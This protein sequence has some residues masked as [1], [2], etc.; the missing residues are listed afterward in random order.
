[1]K[2]K[3]KTIKDLKTIKNKRVLVRVDFNVPIDD[4]QNVLDTTKIVG[5]METIQYLLKKKAKVIL[6]SHMGRP[7]GK[8][9]E[10]KRLWPAGRELEKLLGK[11]IT[12]LNDCVGDEVRAAVEKMKKGDVILLENLR[13]KKEEEANDPDFSKELASYADIFVQDAFGTAHRAHASTVGVTEHLE[14]VAGLLVDKEFTYLKRTLKYPERPFLLVLGGAK[15]SSKIG[16]LDALLD[17][18]DTLLI[19]GG[20]CFTFLKA[21]GYEVGNSLVENDKI[22]VAKRIME[23]AKELGV[24]LVLPN[25]II[26][27]DSLNPA[28]QA[29]VVAAMNMSPGDIG[30]DIGPRAILHFEEKI[31]PAKTVFWNGPMGLFEIEKF[32]RGTF[33]IARYLAELRTFT[34]VGGGESATV[35]QMLDLADKFEHV[36]TGGGATLKF[37]EGHDMPALDVLDDIKTD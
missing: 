17:K 23:H 20:M 1:M 6:M 15:V 11:K 29:R 16:I 26:V 33:E 27:T 14:S 35:V 25:D 19:G 5:A 13:F 12:I 4:E 34:V 30:V 3:K 2:L 21:L 9:D 28:G 22:E 10:K 8:V 32:S 36:S 31:I 7:K 24:E 18:I 37:I